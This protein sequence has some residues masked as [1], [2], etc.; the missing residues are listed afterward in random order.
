MQVSLADQLLDTWFG[1]ALDGPHEAQAR[2]AVWFRAT[3]AFDAEL[4]TRFG[5]LPDRLRA[6]EFG[7]WR[8][9]PHT[10]LARVIA[11]DQIPRNIHRGTPAAFAYDG[12]A[13]DAALDAL[14]RGHDLVVHPLHAVFLYLPFEHA[15]DAS[16]QAR[17]IACFTALRA[18]APDGLA[19]LFDSYLD[20]AHR[21]AEVIA[22]F[23]RFPHRNDVLGR[24]STPQEDAYLRAGGQ[25]F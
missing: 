7:D 6:G 24:E 13:L 20:Y 2:N 23:G 25:R 4:R 11:L 18:R 12:A 19:P 15:E 14:A 3:P 17:S 21:H 8:A 9:A 10:T 16:M 5:T 22:R 1:S